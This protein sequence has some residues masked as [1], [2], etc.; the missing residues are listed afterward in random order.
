MPSQDVSVSY[1][2]ESNAHFVH[3]A[4]HVHITSVKGTIF[5]PNGDELV[6]RSQI[7]RL[8][9]MMLIDEATKESQRTL[10]APVRGKGLYLGSIVPQIYDDNTV[11]TGRE[12]HV[13]AAPED[14]NT[15]PKLS[16]LYMGRVGMNFNA[17][18]K[19]LPTLQNW[20]G[21]DGADFGESHLTYEKNLIQAIQ[22]IL[23][24][25]LPYHSVGWACDQ[26]RN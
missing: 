3:A 2:A 15:P 20:H 19:Y 22:K 5:G 24:I 4:G 8:Y 25:Q 13:Y 26:G 14:M 7:K 23:Y 17:A 6:P 18:A 11:S 1:D 9:E 21:H 10:G 16:N 12:F